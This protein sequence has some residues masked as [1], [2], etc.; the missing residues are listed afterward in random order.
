M[1]KYPLKIFNG[2]KVNIEN[3][4]ILNIT[5]LQYCSLYYVLGTFMRDRKSSCNV[6]DVYTVKTESLTNEDNYL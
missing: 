6:S 1:G 3:I 2:L 5:M 4:L